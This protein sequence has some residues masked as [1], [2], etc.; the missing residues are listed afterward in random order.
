MISECPRGSDS[1]LRRRGCVCVCVCLCVC[2]CVCARV[3]TYMY[4]VYLYRHLPAQAT[5]ANPGAL[6]YSWEVCGGG[7]TKPFLL[8]PGGSQV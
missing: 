5:V 1:R 8:A 2:V 6:V 3:Y 4:C 7:I